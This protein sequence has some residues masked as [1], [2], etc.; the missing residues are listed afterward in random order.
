M[1]SGTTRCRA[2]AL[3]LAAAALVAAC[4][5]GGVLKRE[6][7]YEEELYLALDGT[8]TINVNASVASL[9]A[10]R[11]A[12]LPT[13]PLA[14]VDR[15]RVRALFTG[16]NAAVQRVSLSR[17]DGRRFVHVSVDVPDVR[18]LQQLA[19][20]AWSTYRF[21]PRGDVLEYRQR[22][23]APATKAVGDVGWTGGEIVV[24]RMHVP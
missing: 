2:L 16:A 17:R 9:V 13:D 24:F 18:Q 22:V 14:R 8:A 11:G 1:H 15:E 21:A 3:L 5:G 4:G 7:E 23:G 10:L 19:P 6:Y 12:D 20:F